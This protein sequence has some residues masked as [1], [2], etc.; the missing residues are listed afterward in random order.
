[1]FK[2]IISLV[3]LLASILTFATYSDGISSA[4][5]SYNTKEN[6]VYFGHDKSNE[7]IEWLVLEN[8]GDK[9]FLLSKYLLIG[10]SN[11]AE[12]ANTTWENSE[13]RQWLNNEFINKIFTKQEQDLIL[14][15]DVVNNDNAQY[16]NVAGNN[17]KDKLF[18]LSLD[19][20][21]KYF[22]SDKQRATTYKSG[23]PHRWWLRSPGNEQGD[24]SYVFSKGSIVLFG[25]YSKCESMLGIR[26][27]LWINASLK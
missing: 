26:P 17:T 3:T 19:E 14:I 4:A 12:S 24:T 11:K 22:P 25:D 8:H 1:M 7:P 21:K 27:A 2:R 13:I 6:I 10:Y 18:L 5:Y 20:V 16:G 15:T 9:V 23:A